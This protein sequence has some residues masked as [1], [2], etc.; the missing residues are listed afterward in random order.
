MLFCKCPETT[1]P[2]CYSLLSRQVPISLQID[3]A[4][5]NQSCMQLFP[6]WKGANECVHHKNVSAI[7]QCSWKPGRV[8]M[9][10][11]ISNL[12]PVWVIEYS[13]A[14]LAPDLL[15]WRQNIVYCI[16]LGHKQYP[17]HCIFILLDWCCF[18]WRLYFCI[19]F[20]YFLDNES[21][22]VILEPNR[23]SNIAKRFQHSLIHSW[24][25]CN[26]FIWKDKSCN[27][28]ITRF[29]CSIWPLP[30]VKCE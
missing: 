3:T 2:P 14:H 16:I 6:H 24:Y 5:H 26:D 13:L 7:I 4:F 15:H 19:G 22:L 17:K 11:L 28:G 30:H 12:E 1:F 10:D 20:L 29:P 27:W 25:T 9:F 23:C 8:S 18:S 21:Y